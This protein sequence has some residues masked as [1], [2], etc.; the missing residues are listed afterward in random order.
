MAYEIL[1][2]SKYTLS[3]GAGVVSFPS[4]L[5]YNLTTT[6]RINDNEWLYRDFGV[7]FFDDD[8]VHRFL[9]FGNNPSHATSCSYFAWMLANNIENYELLLL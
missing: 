9:V 6:D 1:N 4:N 3:D 7:D 8:F 5:R 2:G